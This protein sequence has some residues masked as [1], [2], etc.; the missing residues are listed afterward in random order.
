M[1]LD[2]SGKGVV[3]AIRQKAFQQIGVGRSMSRGKPANVVHQR[4]R[5]GRH[6]GK[7]RAGC[8]FPLPYIAR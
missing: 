2:Q 8:N 3:V 1:S 5:A 4:R 6:G 7:P